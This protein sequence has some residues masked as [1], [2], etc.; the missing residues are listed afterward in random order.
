MT[1]NAHRISVVIPT[2]NG[3]AFIEEALQSVF[4]QTRP[5]HE[6]IVVDDH[7][8]DGTA[9]IVDA[10]A[11]TAPVPLRVIGMKRNSGGPAHPINVG[12]RES[13]GAFIA[14]CDQDDVLLPRK[15]E[16]QGRVLDSNPD[17]SLVF[18]LA[19]HIGEPE[20]VCFPSFL[21][22]IRV[23]RLLDSGFRRLDVRA[24][25]A[26]FL[27]FGNIAVGYPGY[28]FRRAHWERKGGVDEGLKIGSDYELA[29]WLCLQG[30]VAFIDEVHYLRR[31]HENNLSLNDV[32]S[33]PMDGLRIKARHLAREPWVLRQ[34]K[35][36]AN[37]LKDEY[38]GYG[39]WARERG[40]YRTSAKFHGLSLKVWKW[41]PRTFWA[42]G[43]LLP[44]MIC[45]MALRLE[46]RAS[47]TTPEK[48]K[49]NVGERTLV[50][51]CPSSVGQD[52]KGRAIQ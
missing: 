13:T 18:S 15:L 41:D 12:V 42:L 38:Y 22:R 46:S 8:S 48:C 19:G 27:R 45:R 31:V 20:R 5:A 30:D 29:S 2:Y 50:R 35:T 17:I 16:A 52:Q 43:V 9:E 10:I 25:F 28:L 51:N 33:A 49:L 11:R 47:T 14:V 36:L 37:D 7:S 44:H 3:S 21:D 24:S 23:H 26:L 4:A 1:D 6:I 34:D 39:Y 32:Y 40:D